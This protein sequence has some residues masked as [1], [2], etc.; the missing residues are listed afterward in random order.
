MDEN[1]WQSARFMQEDGPRMMEQAITMFESRLNDLQ[2]YQDTLKRKADDLQKSIGEV[3]A[4]GESSAEAPENLTN[5]RVTVY[6]VA[7]M[8]MVNVS[9]LKFVCILVWFAR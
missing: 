1:E 8:A 4:L 5:N 9:R 7:S 2:H 3:E 6:K